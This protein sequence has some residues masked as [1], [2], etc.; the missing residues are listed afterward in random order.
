MTVGLNSQNNNFMRF[1]LTMNVVYMSK[2]KKKK[3]RNITKN[4]T[5][6]EINKE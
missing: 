2:Q 4:L 5:K 1:W 3:I 6:E